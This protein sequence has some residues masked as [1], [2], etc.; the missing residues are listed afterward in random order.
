MDISM[1]EYGRVTDNILL[2]HG[3]KYG[4]KYGHSKLIAAE[5]TV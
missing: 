4:Q 2:K 5:K 1:A 3:Q